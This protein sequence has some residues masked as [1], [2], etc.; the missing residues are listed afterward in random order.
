MIQSLA[1]HCSAHRKMFG[2]FKSQRVS[3]SVTVQN[4]WEF[5]GVCGKMFGINYPRRMGDEFQHG[6]RIHLS[7]S[8]IFRLFNRLTTQISK[9]LQFRPNLSMSPSFATRV[10]VRQTVGSCQIYHLL[11]PQVAFDQSGHSD[12]ITYFRDGLVSGVSIAIARYAGAASNHQRTTTA[13]ETIHLKLRKTCPKTS[14][15]DPRPT[16]RSSGWW[17]SPRNTKNRDTF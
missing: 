7:F 10:S 1:A 2:N 16:E 4:I 8:K 3:Q 5:Q 6:Q 9:L 12:Q 17:G 11:T 13:S 15:K 14:H